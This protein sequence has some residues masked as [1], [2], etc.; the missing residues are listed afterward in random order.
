MRL[1]RTAS[2]YALTW[3]HGRSELRLWR[4]PF[5]W[6]L[7]W[8]KPTT[9]RP[10]GIRIHCPR[11]ECPATLDRLC[12]ACTV[13]VFDRTVVRRRSHAMSPLS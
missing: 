13:T 2:Y 11:P 7:Q 5:P 8:L 10:V 3:N 1:I 4:R 9:I 12:P 6:R